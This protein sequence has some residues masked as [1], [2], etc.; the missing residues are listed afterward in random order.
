MKLGFYGG[1]LILISGFLPLIGG[2]SGYWGIYFAYIDVSHIVLGAIIALITFLPQLKIVD[3]EDKL[4]A[5][6]V[7]VL[8]A[9]AALWGLASIASSYWWLGVLLMGL[10]CLVGGV[11]AA[12]GGWNEY[13]KIIT[14]P[15]KKTTSKK[16]SSSKKK[17]GPKY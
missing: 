12:W 2:G 9:L 11:L 15:A 10:L 16:K 5:L 1:I 17:S 13:Q 8:G 14:K 6:A 4:L 3:I 7:L